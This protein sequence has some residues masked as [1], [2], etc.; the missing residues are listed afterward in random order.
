MQTHSDAARSGMKLGAVLLSPA[1]TEAVGIRI[2]ERGRE[3][4]RERERNG[5]GFSAQI[6]EREKRESDRNSAKFSTNRET[7]VRL[8]PRLRFG[9]RSGAGWIRSGAGW[10]RT[11]AGERGSVKD[12]W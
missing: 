4:E 5:V 1:P 3:R 12:C 6:A 2:G 10:I 9:L 11:G 8:G 7:N